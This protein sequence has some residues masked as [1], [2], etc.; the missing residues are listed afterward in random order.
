MVMKN[1][2]L[3]F[4]STVTTSGEKCIEREDFY[5]SSLDPEYNILKKQALH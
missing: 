5:L 2:N 1:S 3:Q 4:L